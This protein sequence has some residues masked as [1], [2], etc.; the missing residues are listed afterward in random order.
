MT[1]Q[2]ALGFK[3]CQDAAVKVC[4]DDA[5]QCAAAEQWDYEDVALDLA[6]AIAALPVPSSSS[7]DCGEVQRRDLTDEEVDELSRTMV[8]GNKSVNWL[9]RAVIAKFKAKNGTV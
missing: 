2:Y 1:N 6:E 4:R 9:S 5:E 8:K 3:A 7:E